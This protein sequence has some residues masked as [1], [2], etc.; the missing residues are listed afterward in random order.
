MREEYKRATFLV[1]DNMPETWDA[2]RAEL[3]RK[4]GCD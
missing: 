4:Q 2:F 1:Y 3:F